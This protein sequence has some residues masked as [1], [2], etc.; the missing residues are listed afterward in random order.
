MEFQKVP[1]MRIFGATD[2]GQRCRL[3]VH[4][5]LPYVYVDYPGELD[6]EG[7]VYRRQANPIC[8][9]NY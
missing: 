6:P 2:S 9:L 1:E 7:Y 3:H 5:V 4:G 8:I